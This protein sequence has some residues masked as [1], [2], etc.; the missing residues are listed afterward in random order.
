MNV[1]VY[2][3]HQTDRAILVNN[4]GGDEGVW[5]PKSQID[6]DDN[7]EPSRGEQITLT[8]PRMVTEAIIPN[9]SDEEVTGG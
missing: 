1:N 4:D 8:A 5:L 2:F 9:T 7:V 3:L 6:W